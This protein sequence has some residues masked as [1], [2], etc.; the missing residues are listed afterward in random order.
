MTSDSRY[1]YRINAQVTYSSAEILV[2]DFG[3]LAYSEAAEY[4]QLGVKAGDFVNGQIALGVD[5]FFYFEQLSKTESVPALIY[6]WR[7]E[8]I[9]QETTPLVRGNVCGREG[10]VRDESKTSFARVQSTAD[11][12]SNPNDIAPSYV[13]HCT[14]LETAPMKQFSHPQR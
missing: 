4:L 7:I 1:T 2:I 5:P 8:G 13:L 6:E 10:Y 9:E 3:V 12:I 14:K 11:F